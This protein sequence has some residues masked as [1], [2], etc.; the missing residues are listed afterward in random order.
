[1]ADITLGENALWS[2][3]NGG[4]PPGVTDNIYLN[5]Y[6]LTLDGA[7]ASTYT[8]ATIKGRAS[9]GT[10][11]TAGNLILANATS[12]IVA[13]LSAG[14]IYMVDMAGKAL[15]VT[16]NI[17]GGS[18]GANNPCIKCSSGANSLAINGDIYGGSVAVNSRGVYFS[19]GT[20]TFTVT[21][22][23]TG[24][25]YTNCQGLYLEIAMTI[26]VATAVGGS[27]GGAHGI[28]LNTTGTDVTV[29]MAKGGT[30]ATPPC[31][32]FALWGIARVN[33]TDISNPG[34]PVGWGSGSARMAPGLLLTARDPN[35]A[36]L[37]YYPPSEMTRRRAI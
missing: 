36:A 8:C 7:N 13:S 31:G 2:T 17:Y 4:S 26:T 29:A 3:C 35:G 18:G 23:V 12:T 19:G 37:I 11:H 21:G 27:A 15:T 32:V 33:G 30:G 25:S 10:T 20:V 1:M 14:T 16:G 22:T 34:Y 28:Q 5:G 6:T 9:N 24:G